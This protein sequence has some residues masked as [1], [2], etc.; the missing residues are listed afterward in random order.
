MTENH[1]CHEHWQAVD[2]QRGIA[3]D[4]QLIITQDLF[5]WTIVE[6]QW[7][8]IGTKG[9]SIRNSFPDPIRAQR[10]ANTIRR[11]R[12]SAKSRIGVAYRLR[13]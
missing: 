11:R 2:P 12:A 4:Y 7:G 6:R 1:V 5:G 13:G 3:R 9:Q 10:F 8:R